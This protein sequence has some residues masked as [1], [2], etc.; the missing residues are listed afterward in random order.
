[1]NQYW[2]KLHNKYTKEDWIDKPS[3]FAQSIIKY[4]PKTGQII[5]IGGGQGQD[6]RFFAENE[7]K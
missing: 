7:Y 4:F 6:S 1:M 3:L 5:D 2:N